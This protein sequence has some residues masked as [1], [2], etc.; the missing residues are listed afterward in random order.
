MNEYNFSKVDFHYKLDEEILKCEKSIFPNFKTYS[1]CEKKYASEVVS[2]MSE[3][4]RDR[5]IISFQQLPDVHEKDL[6]A[7]WEEQKHSCNK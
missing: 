5:Y 4:I 6:L 2:A 1:K 3:N 7:S